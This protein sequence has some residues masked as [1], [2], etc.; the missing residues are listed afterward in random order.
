MINQ[1][2][3]ALRYNNLKNQALTIN[4][5]KTSGNAKVF[6]A[7]DQNSTAS[8][9]Y[10]DA[11]SAFAF[12]WFSSGG[13]DIARY[14]LSLSSSGFYL[15]ANINKWPKVNTAIRLPRVVRYIILARN[16]R[17][18]TYRNAIE[19]AKSVLETEQKNLYLIDADSTSDS[20]IIPGDRQ[21][22]R[23]MAGFTP[24]PKYIPQSLS[25]PTLFLGTD[26]LNI[27][28]LNKYDFPWYWSHSIFKN[29]Y[30]V[31]TGSIDLTYD[32]FIQH[33]YDEDITQYKKAFP[34]F[35]NV[36]TWIY[37]DDI[38]PTTHLLYTRSDE[39]TVSAHNII[40]PVITGATC[41]TAGTPVTLSVPSNTFG[42]IINFYLGNGPAASIT[43]TREPTEL[44]FTGGGSPPPCAVN[45]PPFDANY[46]LVSDE[47]IGSLTVLSVNKS[48]DIA[49]ENLTQIQN[50]C[51][52]LTDYGVVFKGAAPIDSASF[53]SAIKTHYGITN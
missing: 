21:T 34:R 45:Y 20:S 37:I 36:A 7:P 50:F 24:I 14:D 35:R 1:V 44:Y 32:Q 2:N 13:I 25:D 5:F 12:K 22:H 18:A 46:L 6:W 43:D 49:L 31:V 41:N 17:Y 48:T 47:S 26:I 15:G 10:I 29:A 19:S 30:P 3:G 8:G 33:N 52:D 11:R 42:T 51:T 38:T 40:V 23:F 53:I 16:S 28:I 39:F 9:D 27:V 4:D